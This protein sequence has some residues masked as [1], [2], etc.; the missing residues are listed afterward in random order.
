[1]RIDQAWIVGR[2]RAEA[3]SASVCQ[4]RGNLFERPRRH[5]RDV[6]TDPSSL[7]RRSCLRYRYE[8]QDRNMPLQKRQMVVLYPSSIR[9]ELTTPLLKEAPAPSSV[10]LRTRESCSLPSCSPG[11]HL[12]WIQQARFSQS[13]LHIN[14]RVEEPACFRKEVSDERIWSA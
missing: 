8:V 11:F 5:V 3:S 2:S 1:M 9:L 12:G 4:T 6:S 13:V 10:C 14:E 7:N